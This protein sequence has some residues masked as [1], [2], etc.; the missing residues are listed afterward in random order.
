[1]EFIVDAH[2]DGKEKYLC[3][4]KETGEDTM[5]QAKR[6]Y[7]EAMDNIGFKLKSQNKNIIFLI[8]LFLKPNINKY[9]SEFDSFKQEKIMKVDNY[10]FKNIFLIIYYILNFK[11]LIFLLMTMMFYLSTF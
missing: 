2:L 6:S 4:G 10:K 3:W 1:M 8:K 5:K 7:E 11:L 9:Y